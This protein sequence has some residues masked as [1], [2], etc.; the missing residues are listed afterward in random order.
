ML[1]Q[2][3]QGISSFSIMVMRVIEVDTLLMAKKRDTDDFKAF[4]ID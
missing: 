3:K 2:S 4:S 1:T